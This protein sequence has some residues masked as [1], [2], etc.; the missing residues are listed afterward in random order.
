MAEGPAAKKPRV[1]GAGT[2][3]TPQL[4]ARTAERVRELQEALDNYLAMASAHARSDVTFG[5]M[6]ADRALQGLERV[7]RLFGA[8][9]PEFGVDWNVADKAKVVLDTLATDP[10][11]DTTRLVAS[12]KLDVFTAYFRDHQWVCL[13]DKLG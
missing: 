11:G 9:F 13:A 6:H 12:N 1:D 10:T 7:F 5:G 4:S 8:L 2:E 3:G